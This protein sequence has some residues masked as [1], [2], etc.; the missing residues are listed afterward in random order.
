MHGANIRPTWVLSAPDGPNVGPMNLAIRDP[1]ALVPEP[2]IWVN[3]TPN[4][5][6]PLDQHNMSVP[7]VGNQY[8]AVMLLLEAKIPSNFT[9]NM[10]YMLF[11]IAEFTDNKTL[12][13][14]ILIKIVARFQI[15]IP[16][17]AEIHSTVYF[18]IKIVCY[19]QEV[20]ACKNMKYRQNILG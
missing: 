14:R 16:K 15:G 18:S 11:R 3:W 9:T 2:A 13:C 4:S 6:L 20:Y 17:T 10:N 7:A 1:P 19:I 12:T 5:L 8:L